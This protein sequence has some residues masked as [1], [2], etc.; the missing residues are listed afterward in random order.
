MG[1]N[2]SPSTTSVLSTITAVPTTT[3][4][5]SGSTATPAPNASSKPAN[6]HLGPPGAVAGIAI[7]AAVVGLL[8]GFLIAWLWM[9]HKG[10]STGRKKRRR[11]KEDEI[12]R[13]PPSRPQI[14]LEDNLLERV[15]DSVVLS[16]MRDLNILIEG[17][18]KNSYH[19]H[20]LDESQGDLARRLHDCGF[21]K[22]SEPSANTLASLLIDPSTRSVAIR[23]IIA[24]TLLSH[25]DW[26][27]PKETSL[28]PPQIAAICETIPP[29]ER[30]FGCEEV[31]YKAFSQW[32]HMTAF[33]I[34]P[35]RTSRD[36]PKPNK[37]KLQGAL[38]LNVERINEVLQ[39]FIKP[40]PE[41][42]R[43]QKEN[44]GA[45]AFK[46]AELGLILFSQPSTWL[47]EWTPPN[48]GS[49]EKNG[50]AGSAILVLF[51]ALSELM[52]RGGKKQTRS[53]VDWVAV[54][55]RVL[56]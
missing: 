46:V 4:F 2:T 32:R 5:D 45:I 33:L 21:G 24:S 44:L 22:S 47:F 14:T 35:V 50:G 49:T 12:S 15:D 31:F 8:L 17:H 40:D 3:K 38:S 53:V 19:L 6:S 55:V 42:Q 37:E 7:G 11:R 48:H 54:E 9:S 27:T 34:Q 18:V 28:L 36:A 20:K 25:I 51:P 1:D 16:S 41:V 56:G 13:I 43:Y 23:H 52:E 10:S 29:I 39:L 30:Q 26:K